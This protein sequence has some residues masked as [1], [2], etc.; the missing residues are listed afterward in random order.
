MQ[1]AAEKHGLSVKRTAHVQLEALVADI[2]ERAV[3]EALRS[4]NSALGSEHFEEE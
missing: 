2:F 3:L 1:K 4:G